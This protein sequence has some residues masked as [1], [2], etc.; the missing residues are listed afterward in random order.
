[1]L[2]PEQVAR[3][4]AREL[5]AGATVRTA[6]SIPLDLRARLE[7]EFGPSARLL[8]CSGHG[9]LRLVSPLGVFDLTPDAW[10]LREVPPGVSAAEVQARICT[11]L[12]CSPDLAEV[13]VD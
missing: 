13:R 6:E 3:R 5:A 4:V 8:S 10:R 1:M 11:P 9:G 7:A 2:T 12:L